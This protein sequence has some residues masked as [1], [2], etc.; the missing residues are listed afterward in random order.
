MF[1]SDSALQTGFNPTPDCDA[2]LHRV[3]RVLQE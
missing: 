1:Y 2:Y 3:W